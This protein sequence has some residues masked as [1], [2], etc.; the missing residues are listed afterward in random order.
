MKYELNKY[1]F[2]SHII[3]NRVLS[4]D[5]VNEKIILLTSDEY[6]NLIYNSNYELEFSRINKEYIES[7]IVIEKSE[8]CFN[9]KMFDKKLKLIKKRLDKFVTFLIIMEKE[10]YGNVYFINDEEFY[11]CI[12]AIRNYCKEMQEC[13]LLL[14]LKYENSNC[15]NNRL[16]NIDKI[17]KKINY[18]C[19]I[20]KSNSDTLLTNEE[21][22]LEDFRINKTKQQQYYKKKS[23]K[24]IDQL[25][26]NKYKYDSNARCA[27][28]YM[29][30]LKNKIIFK[31]QISPLDLICPNLMPHSFIIEHGALIKKCLC[32][33]LSHD[34]VIGILH[35]KTW[36]FNNNI[37]SYNLSINRLKEECITCK[38]IYVCLGQNCKVCYDIE[39][40]LCIPI[41]KAITESLNRK[42]LKIIKETDK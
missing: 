41:G 18:K 20:I 16:K 32:E 12:Y 37:N 34:N 1:C 23:L 39:V 3:S 13:N 11:D 38:Y 5:S 31:D 4:Y 40:P 27:Y 29:C 42:L 22:N 33:P 6:R 19:K 24:Y 15:E 36:I 2:Y 30:V 9:I 8:I 14:I 25:A 7:G 35:N 17:L 21:K 10:Y 26:L 28:N